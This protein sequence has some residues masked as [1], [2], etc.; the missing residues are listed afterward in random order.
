MT[1][2]SRRLFFALW[3]DAPTLEAVLAA[4][5]R[6]LPRGIGRAQRPDQLHLTLEFLG[7]VPESRLQ[8]VLDAGAALSGRTPRF[9]IVFDKVEH[10]KRPEVLCLTASATPE[11]LA[12]FVQALR[13]ELLARGFEP[14]KRPFKA[15]LTLARKVR[16][17]PPLATLQPLPWPAGEFSLV[18][19]TTDPSGSR[20]GTLATW[21]LAS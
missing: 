1:E 11:P 18:E 5:R 15:H 3:P 6:N 14:E 19:S 13:S 9:E 12:A 10:W 17:P 16:R 21:P 8:E 7:S 20:Y 4:L 2:P